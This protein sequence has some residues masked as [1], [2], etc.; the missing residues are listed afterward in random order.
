MFN[1]LTDYMLIGFTAHAT[2]TQLLTNQSQTLEEVA[3]HVRYSTRKSSTNQ[4]TQVA[5]GL[6]CCDIGLIA[7]PS[8]W[9][10]DLNYTEA[11]D[12]ENFLDQLLLK[13]PIH[14]YI[15]RIAVNHE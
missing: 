7:L 2:L 15:S 6:L 12:V 5:N 14:D 13:I 11:P 10:S 3:S 9:L 8:D 4:I 1:D